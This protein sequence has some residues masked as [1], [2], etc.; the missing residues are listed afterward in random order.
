MS[1]R[2]LSLVTATIQSIE[3]ATPFGPDADLIGEFACQADVIESTRH[4]YR[5]HLTEFREWLAH[6]QSRR[7]DAS[8]RLVDATPADV[9]RFMAYL[10]NADRFA[11]SEKAFKR[12]PLSPSARKNT[13]A[14]L[15][16]FYRYLVGV[17]LVAGDPTVSAKPPR[18][19]VRPGVTLTADELRELLEVRSSARQRA[20]TFLLAFT[21]A[22]ADEIRGLRWRDVDFVHSTMIL[23]GKN[24]TY[25]V[26]DIHPRLMAELRRWYVHQGAEADRN[27][28]I[29]QAKSDP[30][31]DYVLLTRS[32]RPMNGTL[33][34]KQL[35]ARATRAGIQL[36]ERDGQKVSRVSPHA[37][38]RTF[39]T[40][41]LNDGQ[42]IDAVADVLG[43]RSVDTTRKHYAFSSNARRKATI[44]AFNV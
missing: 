30:E 6:A 31:T 14:S 24:D 25:R 11:A 3:T 16:S 26:I 18:V 37:L 20:Q 38:R 36:V 12:G 33:I 10:M 22:R 28:A 32:G 44:E 4:K 43:H 1:S 27:P 23:L 42:P 35:K 7:G 39:A 5:V 34:W 9:Q 19:K 21:A 2:Y 8:T 40:L 15:R 13:L 17:Q 41:L 29:R